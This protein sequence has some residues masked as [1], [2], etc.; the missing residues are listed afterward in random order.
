MQGAGRKIP[1]GYILSGRATGQR[2]IISLSGIFSGS[3]GDFYLGIAGEKLASA[4]GIVEEVFTWRKVK[5]ESLD[6]ADQG[7]F[8]S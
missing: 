6:L 4:Y 3:R 1:V 7:A 8:S 5:D 2:V